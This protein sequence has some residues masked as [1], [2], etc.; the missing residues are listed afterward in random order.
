MVPL[1]A[2]WIQRATRYSLSS[3]LFDAIF[4][5]HDGC[6]LAYQRLQV[7]ALGGGL[8]GTVGGVTDGLGNTIQAGGNMVRDSTSSDTGKSSDTGDVESSAAE[9]A[10]TAQSKISEDA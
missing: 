4:Y 10:K 8:A 3:R 1:R 6:S 7:G 5:S 2:L 9:T